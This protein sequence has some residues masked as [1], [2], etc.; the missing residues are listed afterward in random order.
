M[1]EPLL[2]N[3]R[4]YWIYKTI[5]SVDWILMPI[6]KYNYPP[7]YNIIKEKNNKNRDGE[8]GKNENS[9]VIF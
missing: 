2:N 6:L 4:P 7:K 5:L 1:R 8:I 3:N 9:V